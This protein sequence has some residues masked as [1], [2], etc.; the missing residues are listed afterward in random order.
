MKDLLE[1]ANGPILE[2]LSRLVQAQEEQNKMLADILK[3]SE[4]MG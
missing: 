3:K 1:D 2:L 4:G